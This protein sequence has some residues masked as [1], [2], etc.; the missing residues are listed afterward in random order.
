MSEQADFLWG[1]S[2]SCFQIEGA[3]KEDGR[4]PSIWDTLCAKKDGIANGD[5][6]DVACDHY[7]RYKDDIALMKGM[8]LSAYRF[9]IAWP[10]LLPKGKGALNEQGLDFYDRLIDGLL[11]AKIEPWACLYHW[12]LPQALQDL[13]GW[14]N[15]DAAGWFADYAALCARRYGDRVKHWASFNEFSVFTLFAYA[16]GWGAPNISDRQAHLQAMHV[17][18]LAHGA[19]VD[20]LR[21]LVPG[22]KIGAVHSVQPCKPQDLAP[23]NI[24]A[25]ALFD[26]VWNKAFPDAQLLGHYPERIARQIEPY[27]QAG[28]MARINRPLDWFGLNYYAPMFAKAEAGGMQWDIGWGAAPDEMPRSD[29]GWPMSPEAFQEALHGL[30]KRYRLPI[31]VTENGYGVASGEEPDAAGE[32]QDQGRTAYLQ[33]HI[34]AMLKARREGADVRGYFLWSL[35]DNFEWG[36][37]YGTRFGIVHVDFKTLKRTPKASAKWYEGFIRSFRSSPPGS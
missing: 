30:T 36:A 13:G 16:L 28:D 35:L 12:D 25:S 11:E 29:I 17:V 8:G 27:V 26:E 15:R 32:V 22:A 19:G 21:A 7:H 31:Y 3:A 18:N 2:T 9:S 34:Q 4:G 1:A 20:T 37:G 33:S 5:T 14:Q 23:E 24:E 10:R 6:G